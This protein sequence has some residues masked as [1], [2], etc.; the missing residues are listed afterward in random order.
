MTTTHSLRPTRI[1]LFTDR[2][3]RRDNSLNR[4]IPSKINSNYVFTS[5]AII[6][7][8]Q[9]YRCVFNY[10]SM[11]NL[12]LLSSDFWL[13]RRLT[14]APISAIERTVTTTT[15]QLL[16]SLAGIALLGRGKVSL[17]LLLL[18]PLLVSLPFKLAVSITVKYKRMRRSQIGMTVESR[19][20]A[21]SDTLLASSRL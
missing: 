10:N 8:S 11:L 20:L 17:L 13:T 6:T 3:R 16:V 18:L 21:P 15:S 7:E 4:I 2:I 5:N 12:M 19:Q 1:S 14:Y 9:V